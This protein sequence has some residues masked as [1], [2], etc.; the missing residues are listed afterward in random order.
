[1]RTRKIKGKESKLGK[2]VETGKAQE[3]K[4]K[5]LN[6][7]EQEELKDIAGGPFLRN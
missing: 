2:K 1:M 6:R 5:K 4:G 3:H 7:V